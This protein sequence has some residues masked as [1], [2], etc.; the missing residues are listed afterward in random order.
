MHFFLYNYTKIL[1]ISNARITSA[2]SA[3]TQYSHVFFPLWHSSNNSCKYNYSYYLP[4]Q[5]LLLLLVSSAQLN[6]INHDLIP[7]NLIS[8]RLLSSRS[9]W[10]LIFEGLLILGFGLRISLFSSLILRSFLTF[11]SMTLCKSLTMS[12]LRIATWYF[13][14]KTPTPWA[15]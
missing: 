8:N 3:T 14:V 9:D 13:V 11:I 10:M 7:A 2:F 1:Y 15:A 4:L 6:E 5:L 12:Y